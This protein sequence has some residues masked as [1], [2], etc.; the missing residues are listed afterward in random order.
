MLPGIVKAAT[1]SLVD[2]Q[3]VKDAINNASEAGVDILAKQVDEYVRKK[4]GVNEF[5]CSLEE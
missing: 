1:S 3:A 2:V 4:E 5:R